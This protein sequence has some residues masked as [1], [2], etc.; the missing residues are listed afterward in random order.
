MSEPAT[1]RLAVVAS[2]LSVSVQKEQRVE[3]AGVPDHGL[4]RC[5]AEQRDQRDLAIAPRAEGFRHRLRRAASQLFHLLEGRRFAEL[6]PHPYRGD[7]QDE[8]NQEGKTPAIGLKIRFAEQ[9]AEEQDDHQ[10][11][12]QAQRGGCLNPRREIAAPALRRMF[13]NENRR[14]AIFAAK[15]QTLRQPQQ[16]QK[17]RRGEADGVI[18]GQQADEEGRKAHDQD[19][20]Q[21]RVFAS[22]QIAEAS[23]HARAEGTHGETGGESEQGEDIGGGRIDVGKEIF[24]DD[25]GE[26]AIKV[27]IIPF[28]NRARRKSRQHDPSLLRGHR[29]AAV[30]TPAPWWLGSCLKRLPRELCPRS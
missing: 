20:Q 1:S 3:L 18:I 13:A 24:R 29:A 25:R 11:K 14:A 27:E 26:R 10:R 21:E 6:Q 17:D 4:T 2:T 5:A 23:E 7:Q 15:R 30:V 9:V 8:G 12:Q 22:D 16:D 19:S 28:E